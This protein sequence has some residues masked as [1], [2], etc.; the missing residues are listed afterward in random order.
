M[1]FEVDLGFFASTLSSKLK[2]GVLR[3]P[4]YQTLAKSMGTTGLNPKPLR[5][6]FLA[7]KGLEL[8][9]PRR[10]LPS[11][12]P[13]NIFVIMP[14]HDILHYYPEYFKSSGYTLP[15][16]TITSCNGALSSNPITM[17]KNRGALEKAR[18]Y[19]TEVYA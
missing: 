2:V 1:T 9:E 13:G 14:T 12:K 10:P 19:Q 7:G 16:R 6:I 8:Q 4:P 11:R 5:I 3:Q 17:A 18:A 15:R